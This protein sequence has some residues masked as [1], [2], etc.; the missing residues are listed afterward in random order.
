MQLRTAL[1]AALLTLVACA[2]AWSAHASPYEQRSRDYYETRGD[3]IWDV[4]TDQKVI[5]LTFDDGPDRDDTPAILDLLRQYDARATFF[6]IGSRVEQYPE[7]VMRTAAE[8]HEIANHT[9]NHIYF[10]KRVSAETIREEVRKAEETIRSVTGRSTELFRPPGGYYNDNLIEALRGTGYQVVMWSWH[11]DTEDWRS[12]GV[13][14]IVRKVI[15]NAR[16][17]DIILFHDHVSGPAQTAA[18]LKHILPALRDKGFRF[19]TV[20]ELIRHHRARPV[21]K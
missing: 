20:S 14:H 15:D 4:P 1:A 2:P 7:L 21:K 8:G 16:N 11:Q 5:A 10:N 12:P 19:V 6:V 18:A 3:I 17:G 13:R 9:Y